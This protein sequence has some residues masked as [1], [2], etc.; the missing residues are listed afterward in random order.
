MACV[1]QAREAHRGIVATPKDRT[2]PGLL[3]MWAHAWAKGCAGGWNEKDSVWLHDEH[4]M[5]EQNV[6]P[7]LNRISKL[8]GIKRRYLNYL[9]HTE[10][11][12]AHD[13]VWKMGAFGKQS[14][15]FLENDLCGADIH[16]DSRTILKRLCGRIATQ[17][18]GDQPG[19]DKWQN[20]VF[21]KTVGPDKD[22][23]PLGWEDAIDLSDVPKDVWWS[24]DKP[25]TNEGSVAWKDGFAEATFRKRPR[26]EEPHVVVVDPVQMETEGGGGG[27]AIL[28]LA[29]ILVA[30]VGVS[31]SG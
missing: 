14:K 16:T 6:N 4:M 29:A 13:E 11:K 2:D 26:R 15:T 24:K 3:Q 12:V 8:T 18:G 19:A 5:I 1:E 23:P 21:L 20:D 30:V 10:G 31:F 7:F 22:Y 28:V 27:G 9:L 25:P 17:M